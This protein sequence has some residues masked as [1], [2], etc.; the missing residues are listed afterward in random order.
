MKKK[1]ISLLLPIMILMS[2]VIPV[3]AYEYNTDFVTVNITVNDITNVD[4]PLDTIVER[5]S[6]TVSNFDMTEYGESF[7][8][9]SIL[10]NGVTYLHV[11][12]KLHEYLYGKSNVEEKLK[13]DKTGETRIFMGRSVGSIMYKNGNYIFALPQYINVYNNDEINICLYDEGYNQAIASFD[14]SYV[15][16]KT[17]TELDLNL[18]MHHWEPEIKEDIMGAYIV[19][20]NGILLTDESGNII[21]T[22]D[23]GN[24]TV[25]FDTPGIYKLTILPTIG[26]YLSQKG[27]TTVVWWEEEDVTTVIGQYKK[28]INTITY[29]NSSDLDEASSQRKTVDE[30]NSIG[31][32]GIALTNYDDWFGGNVNEKYDETEIVKVGETTNLFSITKTV[33]SHDITETHKEL[34][35]HE[36]FVSGSAVQKIDYT[37][38]WVVV[39]VTDDLTVTSAYKTDK[40]L[41]VNTINSDN[42]TGMVFCAAYDKQNEGI[43]A[44]IKTDDYS[45][46]MSFAFA[47]NHDYYRLFMWDDD[48]KAYSKVYE[49]EERPTQ[50][51]YSRA[52][53]TN[54]FITGSDK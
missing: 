9:I 29:L 43:L 41:H 28:L 15:N 25:K 8:G 19:D 49:Y 35:R 3:E 34:V 22:D 50:W 45:D 30:L 11:L 32:H 37:T 27:G 31:C 13:I 38:P 33:E 18:F 4:N 53:P 23:N 47:Q 5:M 12:L 16:V 51:N 40:T 42:K 17:G 1:F 7:S 52:Y 26:Y 10:D 36:Q 44:E 6:L 54:V 48:M 46:N 24:F 39:N 20:E 14:E 2:F 21:T